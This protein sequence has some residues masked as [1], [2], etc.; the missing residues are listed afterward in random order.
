MFV[1]AHWDANRPEGWP[2]G[3]P[4]NS[5]RGSFDSEE[6]HQLKHMIMSSWFP[7]LYNV[8]GKNRAKAQGLSS[9]ACE[10]HDS[11]TDP[12]SRVLI[13][14]RSEMEVL[15]SPPSSDLKSDNMLCPTYYQ[16]TILGSKYMCVEEW[17]PTP[18]FNDLSLRKRVSWGLSM[19][20]CA[21]PILCSWVSTGFCP[22]SKPFT[23]LE[24][25]TVMSRMCPEWDLWWGHSSS[26]WKHQEQMACPVKKGLLSWPLLNLPRVY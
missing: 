24:A 16:I 5:Q 2:E 4:A 14:N 13:T 10:T 25:W 20:P 18:A 23:T 22:G 7:Q 6:V 1:C 15:F 12:F 19:G 3:T 17:E 11:I 21:L 8:V 26:I 9:L